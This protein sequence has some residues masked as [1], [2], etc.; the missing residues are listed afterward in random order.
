MY[1]YEEWFTTDDIPDYLKTIEGIDEWRTINDFPDY[2]VSVY[3][4]VYS[5][6]SERLLSPGDNDGYLCVVL[7]KDAKMYTKK[8]HRLVA[9]TF[10]PNPMGKQE[11]N[12]KDG[13]KRNNRLTN[14]EWC[15]REENI[16]HAVRNG[17][18]KRPYDAGSPRKRIRIVET[19]ELFDSISDCARHIGDDPSH[20]HISSCINGRRKT[21]KG[22]HYEEVI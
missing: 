18:Q 17:L 2:E 10:I 13:V 12:H 5:K 4:E 6:R 9:E 20:T 21:H 16:Q 22:Y 7:C 19:G 11:V 8:I 1:E 3:G 15:T 14:L